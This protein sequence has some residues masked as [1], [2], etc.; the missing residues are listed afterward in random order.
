MA[1]T[2]ASP[3]T[4]TDDQRWQA[5]LD[6]DAATDGL[7]FMCV[8]TTGI[9]CRP[10]CPARR[11]HRENV[12]FV[13]SVQAARREGYR[14]C[15]R[16]KPDDAAS[17]ADNRAATIAAIC[18]RI[19]SSEERLS[20]DQLAAEAG[21]SRFHF[22]RV[23]KEVTGVTPKAYETALRS[24][25]VRNHLVTT[26]TVTQAV[27]DAGFA[28]NGRF[29]A[30]TND[31]LGMTPGHYRRGGQDM[32]IRVAFGQS[33]LGTVLVAATESGICAITIGDEAEPLRTD[34][35]RRFPNASFRDGDHDFERTVSEVVGLVEEPAHGI[36][37]P[38]DIRGTAFQQ[39]VWQAL[40][41]IP[42]G[43]TASYGE[44]A[45][46]IGSPK[47]ARAVASACGQ[48]NLAVAVPCHRAVGKNGSLT[49]YHWGLERKRELLEREASA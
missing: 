27:Y 12:H 39:R 42:A 41:D 43:A 26:L 32:T 45:T 22:H 34:L 30:S 48:N 31:M 14:S 8:H 11:P 4:L 3:Q 46:R 2:F 10:T 28:S 16:C 35:A 13:D 24:N 17:L 36:N 5:I 6:R 23:F 47:S 7:F 44:I 1:T 25:R 19:E 18:E 37:L 29:Y 9:Y 15:K 49:G 40:R 33:S 38:L 20:L 21:M